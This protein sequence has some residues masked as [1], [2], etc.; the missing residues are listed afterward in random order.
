MKRIITVQDLSCF[1]KCS[2]SIA[3]PVLSAAG[4]EAVPLPTTLLST[5]TGY[6][7]PVRLDVADF[8]EKTVVHWASVGFKADALHIGYLAGRAQ[9]DVALALARQMKGSQTLIIVDPAMGDNGRLYRGI[10]KDFPKALQS[11][12]ALADV[13]LPNTTEA[14]LLLDRHS[15]V[16]DDPASLHATLCQL[17]ELGPKNIVL[18]GVGNAP[19]TTG[20]L[21][22]SAADDSA[23]WVVTEKVAGKYHGAGDLFAACFSAAMVR[24]KTLRQSAE[25][26]TQFT[27][28]VVRQTA[29]L[30]GR[31]TREGLVFEPCLGQLAAIFK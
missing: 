15:M 26:A 10:S 12:C 8:A 30:P 5:H 23:S 20:A 31:D 11:L 3:L 17:A 2:L 14:A 9:L 1:G 6:D 29:L 18:T 19:G 28:D 21:C 7:T 24:G 25:I 13:L 27:V 16:P 22:Y 4:V